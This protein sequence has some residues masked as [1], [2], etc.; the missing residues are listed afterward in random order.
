MRT[1]LATLAILTAVACSHGSPNNLA[2]QSP[3]AQAHDAA[4]CPAACPGASVVETSPAGDKCRCWSHKVAMQY[5]FAFPDSEEKLAYAKRRWQHAVGIA[6]GCKLQGLG[7]E[8][9]PDGNEMQCVRYEGP[10]P[11][12]LLKRIA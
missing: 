1:I 4:G 11:D 10:P 9:T 7:W 12:E 6:Q 8:A 3:S 5:T 2:M